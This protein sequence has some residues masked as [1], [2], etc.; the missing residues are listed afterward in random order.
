[1]QTRAI[2]PRRAPPGWGVR[3]APVQLSQVFLTYSEN[4]KPCLHLRADLVSYASDHACC[5]QTW[6]FLPVWWVL[7]SPPPEVWWSPR[8]HRTQHRVNQHRDHGLGRSQGAL[9]TGLPRPSWPGHTGCTWSDSKELL[10]DK[11]PESLS[12]AGH[13]GTLCLAPRS[14]PPSKSRCA[15]HASQLCRQLRPP[16]RDPSPQAQSRSPRLRTV[17]WVC[18]VLSCPGP[19]GLSSWS[20]GSRTPLK[21]QKQKPLGVTQDHLTWGSVQQGSSL[22]TTEMNCG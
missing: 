11:P 18:C 21:G 8:S 1:M 5:S 9:D 7:G 12:G 17:S 13:M 14:R 22:E 4:W 3:C 16:H 6:T 10:G 19:G 20:E 15:A 2:I